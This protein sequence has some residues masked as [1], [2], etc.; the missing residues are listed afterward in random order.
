M[1]DEPSILPVPVDLPI[2]AGQ[3]P[4]GVAIAAIALNMA[5]KYHDMNIVKDG[6]LYQQYKLEGRNLPPSKLEMVFKDAR[7]IELYLI[8]SNDRI[9]ELLVGTAARV[10]EDLITRTE[11]EPTDDDKDL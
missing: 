9:N 5:M 3:I 11:G 8:E 1:T 7:E 2:P 10:I 4:A 6:A